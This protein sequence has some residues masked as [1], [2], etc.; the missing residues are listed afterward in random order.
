MGLNIDLRW[1]Q[2]AAVIAIASFSMAGCGGGGG[3]SDSATSSTDTA[4]DSS[5]PGTTQ[6]PTTTNPDPTGNHAPTLSGS[7][8]SSV[9]IDTEYS[10]QFAAEDADGDALT[11]SV[12]NMPGWAHFD[13]ESRVL[14]GTPTAADMGSYS[15]IVITATDGNATVTMPAFTVDVVP[16]ASGQVTVSWHAPTTNTDGSALTDLAG[17]KIYFGNTADNLNRTVRVDNAG[18]SNFVIDNLTPATYFFVITALNSKGM[19]SAR[20]SLV[21]KTL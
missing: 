9:V 4:V 7:P 16:T 6:T 5:A 1:M 19:E 13:A 14:S 20:S 21:S 3:G 12:Q 11:V 15:N 2:R 10:F 8:A 17:Y 18:L